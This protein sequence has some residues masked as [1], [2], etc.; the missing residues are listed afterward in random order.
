MLVRARR[1]HAY[2][3]GKP[4]DAEPFP[5]VLTEV[6]EG[7]GVIPRIRRA[8]HAYASLH[9]LGRLHLAM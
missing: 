3:S 4:L 9:Q 8:M 2:F 1:T 6:A 7:V 5:E